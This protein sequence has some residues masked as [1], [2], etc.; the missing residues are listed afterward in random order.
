MSNYNPKLSVIVP[1]FNEQERLF[2]LDEICKYFLPATEIIVVNDGSTDSTVELLKKYLK[3]YRNIKIISYVPNRGKGYAVRQGMLAA[4]GVYRLFLDIDLSTSP[5]HWPEFSRHL[6]EADVIIGSRR[7]ANAVIA[8][9]QSVLRENMGRVFTWLSRVFLATPVNDFTCGFKVFSADAAQKIFS[10]SLIDRWGFDAE[11]LFIAHSLGLKI[12]SLPVTWT[13]DP[14]T[15][16]SLFRDTLTSLT[17]L[18]R[19]RWNSLL[20]KYR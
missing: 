12:V 19:I 7:S 13:N 11:I 9:R 16:V 3:K 10:R 15:R 20:G 8:G 1:V 4:K 6:R 14:N 17:D 18:L 2:H 5:K